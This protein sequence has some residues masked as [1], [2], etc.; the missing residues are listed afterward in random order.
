MLPS[1]D[2]KNLTSIVTPSLF[3]S[4]FWN[5]AM[6]II[7]G[8]IVLIFEYW[9]GL[10][11]QLTQSNKSPHYHIAVLFIVVMLCVSI[12]FA[13]NC[14][15]AWFH[16]HEYMREHFAL[17]ALC[18]ALSLGLVLVLSLVYGFMPWKIHETIFQLITNKPISKPDTRFIDYIFLIVFYGIILYILKQQHKSWRG[19]KSVNQYQRE[20]RSET[21]GFIVEGFNELTRL[22]KRE[23]PLR[24]Y[25][26]PSLKQFISQLEPVTDSLAWKDIAIELILLSSSSY[27]FDLNTGWHDKEHC[28]VGRNVN[29]GD[30]V[31]VHPYQDEISEVK[32]K[33]FLKYAERIT[34]SE[35]RTT[36]EIIVAAKGNNAKLIDNW[37]D[38]PIRYETEASLLDCLVDFKDY[39]HDIKRRVLYNRLPDSDLILTNVYV[40][41]QFFLSNGVKQSSSIEEYLN[42]WL[43][44]PSQRQLALLGEYGQGKSTAALMWAYHLCCGKSKPF[45]RIPLL[46]ELRGTSPRNLTPLQLL[47]AWAAQYNIN[48]RALMRLL[49]A[50]KLVLIFEGFDE[51]AL[52]GD[53]DMRHKHFK[54]LWQFAYPQSK[55]LI[56][57]RPNLFLDEEQMKAALGISCPIGNLPYCEALRL[58]PFDPEQIKEAL[59]S[60]KKMVIDQ[61]HALV[62]KNP[63]FHELVSRPSL[64]H[65]VAV[66]WERERL[67]ENVD[68]LTSAYVMN[69]FIRHSY[70]RQG[71]KEADSP[72]F[73]A[74]T[75]LER[76]Y[77][78]TGIAAHMATKQL[79]N[80]ITSTQLNEAITDLIACIPESVSTDSSAISG[81]TTRPLR[82]R[83]QDTEHGTEHV[84]TDV[85]A[86]GL[87]V[88]DPASPGTFRFGHKS[89]MEY[90]FAAVIAERIQNVKPEKARAVFKDTNAQIED[91]LLLPVAI[92]FLAELLVGVKGGKETEHAARNSLSQSNFSELLLARVL[93]EL[94]ICAQRYS[95]KPSYTV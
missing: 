9:S 7:G 13:K 4:L 84:K 64:L 18:T 31:F 36:G 57:G 86:C 67:Y 28:W 81:E 90:L 41:S 24:Q 21:V 44:E 56:T 12:L 48:P 93:H 52:V 88:D 89:F 8:I 27:D 37:M 76:E 63:R 30:L 51:M 72:G 46:I 61:I 69:L 38:L 42:N 32:L 23:P 94:F 11:Q 50:G 26:E 71:L 29:T 43:N 70:T 83:I 49:I 87:L 58:S 68:K 85:R 60:Y 6:P 80:Q 19:L 95:A 34:K 45:G 79:P 35:N 55:I 33:E 3:K 15:R 74:L 54:T 22:I 16:H 73:M 92:E 62:L 78:M 91:V 39:F 14:L 2:E 20:Q 66:L 65:I 40:P 59:R 77:F 82:G 10:F 47:G 25:S 5:L 1:K 17:S 53:F 75:T